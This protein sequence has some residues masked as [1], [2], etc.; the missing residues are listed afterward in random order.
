MFDPRARQ[1]S[2][3]SELRN[4]LLLSG[5]LAVIFYVFVQP[6]RLDLT[7]SD[8][9]C[10]QLNHQWQT[11]YQ[12][13]FTFSESW[14]RDE[15]DCPSVRS[16]LVR[17]LQFL[18]Q[19]QIQPTAGAGRGVDFYQ[20]LQRQSPVLHRDLLFSRAGRARFDD[21]R[22]TLNDLVLA[23]NNPLQV[24]SILVH[25]M[26][27]LEE[28]INTHV[29]CQRDRSMVCDAALIDD[30]QNGGAY[31]FNIYFLHLVRQHSNASAFHKKLAQRQ[32]Q[33]IFNN[34]F[35]QL[36]PDAAEKYQLEEPD[37][38]SASR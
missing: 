38:L 3:R 22:V 32:M 27:H 30:P 11:K 13:D 37:W 4:L 7:L 35:N 19:L 28:G 17:G 1:K 25:E 18:D 5:F 26:R 31:N 15:F 2:N 33:T 21:R 10:Q 16:G 29:P 6:E 34:H 14:K 8:D 9:Q 24:A 20:R 36:P 12:S 23:D